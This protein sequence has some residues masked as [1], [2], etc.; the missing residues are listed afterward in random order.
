[1]SVVPHNASRTGS[2]V[3]GDPATLS[4]ES[5]SNHG[6]RPFACRGPL[7]GR[8]NGLYGTNANESAITLIYGFPSNVQHDDLLADCMLGERHDD[9]MDM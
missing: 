8:R 1:M 2:V 5:L 4:S 9:P 6:A 7:W 3:L